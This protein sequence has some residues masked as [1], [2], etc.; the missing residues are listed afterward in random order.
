MDAYNSWYHVNG[1]TYGSWLPGDRR[2][3]RTKEHKQHVEGDYKEPPLPGA[4]DGLRTFASAEMKQAAVHLN[5]GQCELAGKALIEML[6]DQ[7]IEVI[8][9]AIDAVHFHLL[10]RFPSAKVRPRVA[11][12]KKHATFVLRDE[13][14]IGKLWA[15]TGKVTPIADREHQ[16]KVFSYIERH[17]QKNAWLWT[18]RQGV[19]WPTTIN[20]Q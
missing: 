19:S 16:L 3:W 18:F 10:G 15:E 9:L 11:R 1:N 2:G 12:A 5:A 20:K 6:L 8:V 17:K 13:G 4:G 14:H 7:R